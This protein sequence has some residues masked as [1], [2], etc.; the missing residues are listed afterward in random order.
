MELEDIDVKDYLSVKERSNLKFLNDSSN[1]I[2]DEIKKS[3]DFLNISISDLFKNWSAIMQDILADFALFFNSINNYSNYFE[4]INDVNTWW[5]GVS[6][7]LKDF[8][9]IFIKDKRSIYFGITLIMLSF[10]V[11]FIQISHNII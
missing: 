11:Y 9:S 7:L 4:D 10:M 8:I 2:S 5:K 3:E 1:K 6:N